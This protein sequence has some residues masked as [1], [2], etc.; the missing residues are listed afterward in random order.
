MHH[1]SVLGFCRTNLCIDV[2][3][4]L[5]GSHLHLFRPHLFPLAFEVRHLCMG[6]RAALQESNHLHCHLLQPWLESQMCDGTDHWRSFSSGHP[7]HGRSGRP[8]GLA[9]AVHSGRLNHGRL[10]HH[11]QSTP[12][13]ASC[14]PLTALY[15]CL[16]CPG[17]HVW[18]LLRAKHLGLISSASMREGVSGLI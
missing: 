7:V 16:A 3:G 11:A 8:Q 12:L 4:Y 5:E 9:V 10:W 13:H 18:R 1:T 15:F 14:L 6:V 2:R 17:M